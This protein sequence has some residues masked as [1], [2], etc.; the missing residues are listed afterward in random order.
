MAE[1]HLKVHIAL[2]GGQPY[3]IFLGIKEFRPDKVIMVCSDQRD[4]DRIA[5]VAEID[6][7]R[8]EV[9]VV[10]PVNQKSVYEVIQDRIVSQMSPDNE[11]SVNI[12]GGTKIWA[13]V[14][15]DLLHGRNNVKLFYIDQNNNLYDLAAINQTPSNLDF[16]MDDVFKLNGAK[17]Q[18]YTSFSD[19]KDQ[20][21]SAIA[22]IED[23]YKKNHIVLHK[24][25][26]PDRCKNREMVPH[27]YHPGPFDGCSLKFDDS[28][29]GDGHAELSF[30]VKNHDRHDYSL[31]AP[32]LRDLL[33]FTGW[34]ELKVAKMLSRWKSSHDIRLGVSFAYTSAPNKPITKNEI[35][36]IM[37]TGNRLLFVECK[38]QINNLTDIDKFNN[39]VKI[40]GG[41]GCLSL[42]VTLYSMQTNAIEKCKD[43]EVMYFSIED[44]RKEFRHQLTVYPNGAGRLDPNTLKEQTDEYVQQRLNDLLD[45]GLKKSN[46]K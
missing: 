10:D 19:Y 13:I 30:L 40:F 33:F 15:Y 45:K 7:S 28:E 24:M 18:H 44:T 11:Y 8:R 5:G 22:A 25:T 39:A 42:F 16:E 26:H 21:F 27:H 14:L 32:H 20:D 37:N 23:I 41:K 43:S 6:A 29:T 1:E 34:F 3:P 36:I 35:D 9:V 46:K 4:A 12:T 31:D 2:V 38:T 17:V